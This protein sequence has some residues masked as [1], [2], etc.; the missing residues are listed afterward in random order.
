MDTLR[1]ILSDANKD[2]NTIM[3]HAG[4]SYFRNFME[5][6]YL[7]EK[8]LP[9]PDDPVPYTAPTIESEVQTKGIMWQ[10]LK[11]L[12]TVRNPKLHPM[13][14]EMMF[15]DALENVT[16]EEAIVLIH[17]K[18]QSLPSIYGNILLKDLY[19]VGYFK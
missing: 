3:K 14:R 17:M 15:I 1:E 16:A 2:I 5:A 10:F 18:N 8:R 11:K 12:D 9:L 13:K 4:N 19:R 7:K 6:A